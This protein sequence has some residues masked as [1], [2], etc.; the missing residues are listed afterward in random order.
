MKLFS[1][2]P[3]TA[4]KTDDA[5]EAARSRE[6]SRR[7]ADLIFEHVSNDPALFGMRHA[8]EVSKAPIPPQARYGDFET[9]GLADAEDLQRVLQECGDP[10]SGKWMLI[11]SLVTC[12]AVF[13][14]G[15]DGE[16]LV[17]LPTDAD[18]IVSP[19]GAMIAVEECSHLLTE[20]DWLDGLLGD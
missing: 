6:C 8:G 12:R 10:S 19:D 14:Y 17:C 13:Y 7:I 20:T 11:R 9:V 15:D 3:V 4:A 5:A 18:P 16:A 1:I 2:T